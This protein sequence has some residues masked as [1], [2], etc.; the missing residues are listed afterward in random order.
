MKNVRM[1][2][3]L[4][5]MLLIGAYSCADGGGFGANPYD[6]STPVTVSEWPK[7][8]SFEPD[9][10]KAGDE[11]T[12]NGVNF[13]TAT[14]VTFGGREAESFEIIDDATI[15]AILSPFG[16]SGAVAVTNH[17]GE[18]SLPG[19]VYQWPDVI[20]D[21]PNL[22]LKGTATSSTPFSGF[23]ATSVNDGQKNSA[24]VAE[25]N[26][27]GI[28]RWVMIELDVLQEINTVITY[29]DPNAAGTDYK[30]EVS[31]DGETFVTIAEEKGWESN[32][33]DAGKKKLRFDAVN[34]RFVRLSELYNSLTPYD[35][36]MYEF[37]IYDTPPAT[38]VALKKPAT[39]D[40]E[41]NAGSMFH[42]TDGKLAN[43]WQCDNTHTDHWA[44]V[45]LGDP[46]SINNI[47][48]SWDGG[49]YPKNIRISLSTD[50]ESWEEAYSITGW[51]ATV[52]PREP[53]ETVWTKAV[54]DISFDE[55][56][57][58]YIKV[59]FSESSSVWAIGILELE[60][61]NRL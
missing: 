58:R 59:D 27:E 37:E 13:S 7:V 20:T 36:T 40:C 6:P 60:A 16:N 46:T 2:I 22:A 8:I 25:N 11:I 19:F 32:G 49:A 39:A 48:I 15:K 34:A 1:S 9:R 29:W 21:N 61:Y 38:N 10:G 3:I 5:G 33:S 45:D 54:T 26:T 44:T 51:E 55:T 24:W 28:E 50:N 23:F 31:E 57:A 41:A 53:G 17:K 56:E 14:A 42:I 4:A 12:I 43:M 52:E 30:L 18:R 35:M 47:V